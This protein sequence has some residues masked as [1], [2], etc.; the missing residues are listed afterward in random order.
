MSVAF[1]GMF[2]N[3]M[4]IALFV[5]TLADGVGFLIFR[6]DRWFHFLEHGF[7]FGAV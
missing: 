3:T 7:D 2:V 4:T 1:Y 6:R 5:D